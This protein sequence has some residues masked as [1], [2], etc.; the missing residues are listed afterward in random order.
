M[1]YTPAEA[2][3]VGDFLAEE[4]DLRGW[5]QAEF[6]EILG[7][8]AQYV[9]EI[10]SNKKEITRDSAAQIGAAL[11]TSAGHWL[12]LQ[13]TYHL[14]KQAQDDATQEI[15]SE[16]RR[17][18]QLTNLAPMAVLRKRGYISGNTVQEQEEQLKRLYRIDDIGDE[19]AILVAARRSLP[20]ASVSPTQLAWIVCV[21]DKAEAVSVGKYDPEEL[22]KLAKRLSRIVQSPEDFASLPDLFAQAG[23]RLVYIE[24]FPSS[25]MDGCTFLLDNGSPVIGISGRGKRLDKVLFTILH[26]IAHLLLKHLQPGQYIIDDENLTS[27]LEEQADELAGSFV[28]S[29]PLPALPMR[30]STGWVK[31]TASERGVHWIVLVGHLQKR[32]RLPWRTTLV[33]GAPTVSEQLE[34]W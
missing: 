34:A 26:E 33:K 29:A 16:V 20:G 4:L 25:K 13:D 22:R 28:F 24:A 18:A 7:R 9:S 3:P 17:R 2:F 15:L 6:A 21:R 8:P 23:V 27:M 19:P 10:V 31:A 12:K 30:V 1:S 32:K 5:T 11:G 14:W